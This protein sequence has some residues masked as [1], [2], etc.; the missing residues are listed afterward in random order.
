MVV[1]GKRID[2]AAIGN[3]LH[4]DVRKDLVKVFG[5]SKIVNI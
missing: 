1:D 4:E 2:M 5:C 3:C